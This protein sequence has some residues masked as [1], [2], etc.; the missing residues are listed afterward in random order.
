MDRSPPKRP[1][2]YNPPPPLDETVVRQNTKHIQFQSTAIK[3]ESPPKRPPGSSP[4][5][6]AA[7]ATVVPT[8]TQFQV[9]EAHPVSQAGP[10]IGPYVQ[11]AETLATKTQ[12]VTCVP[13][14]S[15][16][17]AS[18]QATSEEM[19]HVI[20][21]TLQLSHRVHHIAMQSW[22][23]CPG[24]NQLSQAIPHATQ[25]TVQGRIFL[26]CQ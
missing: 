21:T 19:T 5:P 3:Q 16:T 8:T 11:R 26:K 10:V 12:P 15:E 2:G 7:N 18:W 9:I 6:S 4:P 25:L 1:P 22:D 24:H 13:K 20:P 17:L 23:Q 14:A